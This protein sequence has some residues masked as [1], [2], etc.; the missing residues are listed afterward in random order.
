MVS[1]KLRKE[2]LN[3]ATFKISV[4]HFDSWNASQRHHWSSFLAHQVGIMNC[5][6]MSDTPNLPR[7]TAHNTERD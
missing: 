7:V 2:Y 6:N 5:L 4:L 3:M 1:L